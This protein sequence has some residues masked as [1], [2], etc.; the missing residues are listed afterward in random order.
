MMSINVQQPDRYRATIAPT[1]ATIQAM[2]N[3]S[4]RLGQGQIPKKHSR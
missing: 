3:Q 1:N 2:A 4:H